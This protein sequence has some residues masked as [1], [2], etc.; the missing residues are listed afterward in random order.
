MAGSCGELVFLYRA[1]DQ[2]RCIS[3]TSCNP[4]FPD[5]IARL[6]YIFAVPLLS[7]AKAPTEALSAAILGFEIACSDRQWGSSLLF[8]DSRPVHLSSTGSSL[9]FI[10]NRRVHLFSRAPPAPS[11]G[12]VAFVE[13]DTFALPL[14]LPLT[15][16]LSAVRPAPTTANARAPSS[17]P[18]R[19][20]NNACL[21]S[22]RMR[23]MARR[24]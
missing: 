7:P 9:L 22:A 19:P 24:R 14:P 4:S 16:A 17:A 13:P 1:R 20:F 2:A 23:M 18:Q 15:L 8:I 5:P 6:R 11:T 12:F 10:D 3:S 21:H